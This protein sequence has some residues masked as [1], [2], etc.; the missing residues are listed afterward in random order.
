M[1]SSVSSRTRSD[2][3]IPLLT[4]FNGFRGE[5]VCERGCWWGGKFSFDEIGWMEEDDDFREDVRM[6]VMG[7]RARDFNCV[8]R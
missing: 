3:C 1:N 2:G 8:C 7:T 4:S 6:G 5:E